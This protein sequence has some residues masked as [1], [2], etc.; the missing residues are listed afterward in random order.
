MTSR[1]ETCLRRMRRASSTAVSVQ[2][3]SLG[4]LG[5]AGDESVV[6]W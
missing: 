2:S 3:S 6:S 1:A 4:A 5:V